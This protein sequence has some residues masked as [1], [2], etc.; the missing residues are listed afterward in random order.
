M[1]NHWRNT[2]YLRITLALML[3]YEQVKIGNEHKLAP[4]VLILQ[5]SSL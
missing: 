2:R 3:G 5:Q 1:I 4:H